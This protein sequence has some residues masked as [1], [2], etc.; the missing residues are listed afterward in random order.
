MQ[1]GGKLT[2]NY[3]SKCN[4]CCKCTRN[5]NY[6]GELGKAL[7]LLAK[8]KKVNYEGATGVE[9]TEVEGVWFFLRKRTRW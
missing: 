1:A 6:P 4:G 5:K 7:D 8:G 3:P 2:S 9:F